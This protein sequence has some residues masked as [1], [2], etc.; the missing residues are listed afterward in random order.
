MTSANRMGRL[1]LLLVSIN[2]TA[3]LSAQ[4][5]L[6][7]GFWM[8]AGAGT[9]TIRIGNANSSAPIS[10]YGSSGFVRTGFSLSPRVLLGAELMGLLDDHAAKLP[11]DDAV[12]IRNTLLAPVIIWYPWSGGAWLKGGVG[13][14]RVAVTTSTDDDSP[15]V[16]TSGYGTG[17]TFGI[18]I[19]VPIWKRLSLGTDF[20]VYYS[21]LGDV[22][23]FGNQLDDVITTMYTV[24]ISI[25]L[26]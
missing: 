12:S 4:Q 20:G 23:M 1:V 5:P 11:G 8:E 14:A 2:A 9:G 10:L 6:R 26:R 21:A 18:G 16:L 3:P 19:D 7:S 24:N 22:T 25:I 13:V 15:P 17:L